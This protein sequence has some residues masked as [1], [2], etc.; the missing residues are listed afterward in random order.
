MMIR[1]SADNILQGIRYRAA[2]CPVARAIRER[3]PNKAV[4]VGA[5]TILIGNA[6][7]RLIKRVKKMITKYDCAGG[8]EP[9][10]FRLMRV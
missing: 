8:M 10:K 9:F 5:E 3:F 4:I 2:L 1:V 6:R 7:Y